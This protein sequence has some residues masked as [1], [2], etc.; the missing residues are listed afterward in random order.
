MDADNIT[1]PL[2]CNGSC[3]SDDVLNVFINPQL[4]SI[5]T[6]DLISIQ[7]WEIFEVYRNNFGSMEWQRW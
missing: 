7:G 3:I 6:V 2:K 5:T 1:E 4:Q